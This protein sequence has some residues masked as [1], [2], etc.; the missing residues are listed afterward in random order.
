MNRRFEYVTV[1]ITLLAAASSG[2]AEVRLPDGK[3][4]AIGAVTS[5]NDDNEIIN[6]SCSE[7]ST[8]V[9]KPADVRF[10][11]K[12]NGGNFVES[13]RPIDLDGG[14]TITASLNA[15]T[16]SRATDVKVQVLFMILKPEVAC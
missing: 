10:S 5:G 7:N 9:L 11:E 16:N 12:T 1:V 8:V 6:L 3:C 15:L 2:E 14:K 4:V 13:L